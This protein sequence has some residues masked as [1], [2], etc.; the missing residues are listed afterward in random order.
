MGLADRSSALGG[1]LQGGLGSI[2][3][4]ISWEENDLMRIQRRTFGKLA[5]GAAVGSPAPAIAEN[6]PR[7]SGFGV[8]LTARLAPNG[9][10]ALLARQVWGEDSSPKGGLL[11]RPVKL[12]YY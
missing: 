4:H 6:K 2:Q 5:A 10:G 11:R 9:K 8:N 12:V 7:T 3:R 1:A